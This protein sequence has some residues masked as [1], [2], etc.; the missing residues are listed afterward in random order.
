MTDNDMMIKMVRDL[1]R[2]REDYRGYAYVRT[3]RNILIGKEDA[4]IAPLFKGEPYYGHYY[5]LKLEQVEY[6]ADALVRTNRLKIIY[7]DRGKLYCTPE[8]YEMCA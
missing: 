3:M 7:T 5:K 8:Y 6:M 1:E 2:T 4:A